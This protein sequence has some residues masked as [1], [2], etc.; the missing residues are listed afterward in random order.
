VIQ[1]QDIQRAAEFL[2][3]LV[4]RT[5]IMTSRS[6]NALAGAD[7][8]FKAENLQRTG[9]FKIRGALVFMASLSTEE[10]SKGVLTASAGN[11]A[12]GVALAARECGV[13]V[14]VV[15]PE[16]APVAKI[17][18]TRGYGAEVILAGESYD[19][20]VEHAYRLAVERGTI[21][22]P[23]YDDERVVAGQG[24]VGLEIL[25]DV[26]DLDAVVVPIGGGGLIAGIATAVKAMRSDVKIYGVRPA[27]GAG[28]LSRWK[29]GGIPVAM[30]FKTIA[31]GIAVKRPGKV[32]LPIIQ[33]LVD[34]VVEVSDE[35]VSQAIVL[36]LER[37]K[38]IVEGAGAVGLAAVLSGAIRPRGSKTAVV[39]SGGNLDISTLDR[40]VLRG[41]AT[42][43]R[44]L[45]IRTRLDD[46]PGALLGLLRYLADEG[47][48]VLDISHRRVG[49]DLPVNQVEVELTLETRDPAHAEAIRA[50]LLRGGFGELT[51]SA[52]MMSF[53][54][55]N[56]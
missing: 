41:L 28:E 21:Y 34:D 26:P 24:T 40:V 37:M 1:L 30:P 5:P 56:T 19:R 49:L 13:A 33:S 48:N 17:V 55:S 45:L 53:I 47:A 2:A 51:T 54:Q 14:T 10:R 23:A 20:A 52:P 22:V 32:T 8:V 27:G 9:S 18:A 35:H 31:D 4:H 42:A 11:H 50:E 15:M 12:Q 16:T 29:S 46:R 38:L 7:L 44:F 25:D 3:G 36:L 43:G 39:L 6:I